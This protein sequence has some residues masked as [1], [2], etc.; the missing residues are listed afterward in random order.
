MKVKGLPYIP[1]TDNDVERMCESMQVASVDELLKSALPDNLRQTVPLQMGSGLGEQELCAHLEEL[2]D[3]NASPKT[4]VSFLGAGAYNHY[5]PAAVDYLISRSEF[6]TSYTPYQPELSQGTLQAIFEYQTLICQL[7]GME[8]S[9]AS[10]YDGASAAAEAALMARRIT[11]KDRVLIS[12]AVHPEYRETVRTYLKGSDLPPEEVLYCPES[13]TTLPEEIEREFDDNTACLVVQ[14]PNFFGSIERLRELADIV[15]AKKG[16][17]VVVVSEAVAL[18]ML[19]APGELGADIVV[20][21]AQSFG[22][23]LSFGGPYLGFMATRDKYMR[24][25][26]GRIVGQ[27]VDKNGLV[28]YCLTHATR[29]Q[30]IRRERA[31]SNICTNQG[32]SALASAVY[33]TLLG[34]HGITELA[35]TN[36]SKAVYLKEKL[37]S[38]KGV[39]NTFA[40]SIFNEFVIEV[41]GGAEGLL[42]ALLEQN[43]IIGGLLLKRF[44]PELDRHMLVT[45]T[46]MNTVTDMDRFVQAVSAIS[47][48]A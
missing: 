21:E 28:S 18:G 30:H 42:K 22:N 7:T 4:H 2:S 23:T 33:L 13:G 43:S 44:Y 32:L 47:T 15:H 8:L 14:Y 24:Q 11:R 38:V 12:S 16:L 6:C 34:K 1:H 17:L 39:K 46:E 31:T 10:L 19:R 35:K 3:K 41:D 48:G 9:N 5:I 20:G 45:V 27:T 36:L 37:T 29:E 26:P 25:K 40:S